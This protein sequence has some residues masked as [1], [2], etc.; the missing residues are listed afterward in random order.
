MV[1]IF[2]YWFCG[3]LRLQGTSLLQK[4]LELSA[5]VQALK[6]RVSTNVL[7]LDV[8][9]GDGTL[10]RDL[11]ESVLKSGAIRNFVK[12]E[13]LVIGVQFIQSLLGLLAV[14]AVRLGED[15]NRVV[16]DKLLNLGR[17]LRHCA[18]AC[19]SSEE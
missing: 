9:V 17:C 19:C 3:F 14:G 4:V 6:V 13:E 12:L 15:N 5:R 16:V 11:L 2:H 7:L 8:D 18:G 10:A 1:S